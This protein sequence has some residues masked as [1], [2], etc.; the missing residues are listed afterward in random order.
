V[1]TVTM[2]EARARLASLVQAAAAGEEVVIAKGGKPFAR[3]VAVEQPSSAAA[4]EQKPPPRRAGRLKGRIWVADDFDDLLPE[5]I[6][7]AFRRERP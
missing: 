2:T 4:P 1:R 3:L 7:A 6:A 5:E